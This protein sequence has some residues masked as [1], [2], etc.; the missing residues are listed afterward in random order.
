MARVEL[1]MVEALNGTVPRVCMCCGAPAVRFDR[2][3]HYFRT[4]PYQG[5]LCEVHKNHWNWRRSIYSAGWWLFT[6]AAM[7]FFIF[8]PVDDDSNRHLWWLLTGMTA[9]ALAT[10]SGAAYFTS[11]RVTGFMQDVVF[12]AGVSPAFVQALEMLHR[13]GKRPQSVPLEPD[14]LADWPLTQAAAQVMQLARDQARHWGQDHVGTHHVLHG[15][16]EFGGVASQ[17]LEQLSITGEAIQTQ[18]EALGLLEAACQVDGD[19]PWTPA[20]RRAIA[21]ASQEAR[22]FGQRQADEKHLLLG[23]AQEL[24][25]AGVQILLSLGVDLNE[26]KQRAAA[27]VDPS[28][29][30]KIVGNIRPPRW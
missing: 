10:L 1:T 25:G 18:I 23:I 4:D 11:V 8:R 20:V 2:V 19:L 14:I 12:Y 26:L 7:L 21:T 16:C 28:L 24:D 13:S 30:V 22:R 15:L 29:S 5:P 17:G 3:A 6:L 27:M 9:I